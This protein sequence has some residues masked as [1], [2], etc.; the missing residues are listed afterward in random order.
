MKSFTQWFLQQISD[1]TITKEDEFLEQVKIRAKEQQEFDDLTKNKKLCPRCNRLR[2]YY[3][4][5]S[6]DFRCNKCK[7]FFSIN[8]ELK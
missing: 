7:S 2:M 3:R 1:G 8:M 6:N 4:F 5:T